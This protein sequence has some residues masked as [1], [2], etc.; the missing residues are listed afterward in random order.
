MLQASTPM[1]MLASNST[2][3]STFSCDLFR[4]DVGAIETIN[5]TI[6]EAQG[7]ANFE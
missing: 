1:M 2:S 3:W 7:T 6:N 4:N 5:K